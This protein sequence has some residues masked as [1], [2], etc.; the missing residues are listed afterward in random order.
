MLL[1]DDLL[2]LP[3]DGFKFILGQIQQVVDREL[4]DDTVIKSQLLELQMRLEL[5]EISDEEYK[6]AEADLFARL[7]TIKQRQLD[8]L[9]EAVHTAESSSIQ[10]D[11]NLD[12][13]GDPFVES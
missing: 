3:V 11:S 8:L 9:H 4:N 13:F 10:I 5:E 6:I 7:R 1:V 2:F 12:S